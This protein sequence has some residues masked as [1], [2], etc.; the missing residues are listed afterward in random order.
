IMRRSSS[1]SKSPVQTLFAM[2][3]W[4]TLSAFAGSSAA[5][6]CAA[7]ASANTIATIRYGFEVNIA[8][9]PSGAPRDGPSPTNAGPSAPAAP[10]RNYGAAAR[11]ITQPRPPDPR[12]GTR[13]Q[14]EHHAGDRREADQ[15]QQRR[16]DQRQRDRILA[17]AVD[18]AFVDHHPAFRA[19]PD[20]E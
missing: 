14:V 4:R 12:S 20:H 18:E 6:A 17:F 16:R 19:Q 3:S 1:L 2:L 15:Q 11:R 10:R 5:T 9:S 8:A 13:L 7:N